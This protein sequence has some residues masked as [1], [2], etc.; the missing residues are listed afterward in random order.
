MC[1]QP[2]TVKNW[3]CSLT[4]EIAIAPEIAIVAAAAA[5]AVLVPVHDLVFVLVLFPGHARQALLHVGRVALEWKQRT[6]F[7]Q[8]SF[9]AWGVL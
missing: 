3:C 5:V 4:L 8:L 7:G 9:L 2:A 6:Q 1:Y